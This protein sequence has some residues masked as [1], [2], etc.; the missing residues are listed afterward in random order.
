MISL[1]LKVDFLAPANA[2]KM[3]IRGHRIKI[4]KTICLAEATA[5]DQHD[6]WLAHGVSKMM[7]TQGLQTI[8]DALGFMGAESLPRNLSMRA[9]N[10][11]H[12]GG[13]SSPPTRPR[14]LGGSFETRRTRREYFYGESEIP[15]LHNSRPLATRCHGWGVR[16]FCLAG[17]P[18][19][20]NIPT[21]CPLRL[22]GENFFG[23]EYA[24][25]MIMSV[26]VVRLGRRESWVK[27]FESDGQ[28]SARGVPKSEYASQNCMTYG[29]QTRA[30][31]G[32]N[33]ARPKCPDEGEWKAFLR[34]Y[35]AEMAAPEKSRVLDLLA[36]LSHGSDFSVGCYCADERRCHRSELR[37]LLLERGA[38]VE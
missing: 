16:F 36:T 21:P 2:G 8:R 35:R 29:S 19:K 20:Q 37:A 10:S 13:R 5:F 6:K 17:T 9:R 34:K 24:E 32:N 23:L 31:S 18:A 3:I 27:A 22:C 15:I 25:E 14:D 30:K 1:D 4:G 11:L 12:Y 28:A 26:R 38:K 33:E 7:V